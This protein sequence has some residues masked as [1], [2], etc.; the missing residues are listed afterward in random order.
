MPVLAVELDS[1]LIC[2]VY[3]YEQKNGEAVEQGAPTTRPFRFGV[4]CVVEYR[5]RDTVFNLRMLGVPC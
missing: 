4:E 2:T 5:P 1:R 3:Y